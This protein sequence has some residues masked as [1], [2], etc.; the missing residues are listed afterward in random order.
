MIDRIVRIS[1]ATGIFCVIIAGVLKIQHWQWS[2]EV[3]VIGWVIY[4]V[5]VAAA[6]FELY[7]SRYVKK[8]KRVVCMI[9]LLLPI[10]LTGVVYMLVVRKRLLYK[11][12]PNIHFDF[13]Q[14]K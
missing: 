7:K 1:F 10:G 5:F 3:A 2:Y 12:M 6:I 14:E 13:D 8:W 4:Y 11:R 9:L